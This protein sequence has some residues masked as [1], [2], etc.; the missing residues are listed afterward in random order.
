MPED[1]DA[2][3]LC[4]ERQ[5]G[6]CR[7]LAPIQT[8]QNAVREL[9]QQVNE[10][11]ML[12]YVSIQDV[13]PEPAAANKAQPKP[14]QRRATSSDPQGKHLFCLVKVLVVSNNIT[15][16]MFFPISTPHVRLRR[17]EDTWDVLPPALSFWEPLGLSPT[18]GPKNIMAYC[19]YPSSE[20]LNEPVTSFLDSIS[21]AYESC[22]FGSHVRGPEIEHIASNGLVSASV[23]CGESDNWRPTAQNCLQAVRDTCSSLGRYLSRIDFKKRAK[24]EDSP[25][26]DAIV[27]Y[28]VN[29]FSDPHNL[30]QLCSAFWALFQA[31]LPSNPSSRAGDDSRPELVLQLV[32]VKYIASFEA[33]VV[34]EPSLLTRFAREVYDRCPPKQPSN[35]HTALSI[36]SAPSIQ[37]EETLPKSIP[38]RVTAEPPS[39]LL[40]ENSYIHV[41][42]AISVDGAWLTAAWT[43]NPGKHQATVS[44]CLNNRSFVEVAREI[45]QTSL[46][47]MSARRVTWR[48]CIARA[49]VMERE[50]QDG[51]FIPASRSK[52]LATNCSSAWQVLVTSPCPLVI[53]TA[54]VSVNPNPSFCVTSNLPALSASQNQASGNAGVSTPGGNTPQPGVSPDAHGFTPAATPSDGNTSAPSVDPAS[55]PD[56]RLVDVTDES[57]GVILQHRL[58]NSNSTTEFR[59]ALASGYLIKRGA[60]SNT[61]AVAAGS[62][63][64]KPDHHPDTPRGPIAVGINLL[65]I[66]STPG[67]HQPQRAAQA[68]Q[69]QAAAA[70]AA[71]AQ[72]AHAHQ[73]ASS[74]APTPTSSHNPNISIPLQHLE[75]AAAAAGGGAGGASGNG[76]AGN[77]AAAGSNVNSPLP[78][79]AGGAM[80]QGIGAAA[81]AAAGHAGAGGG[82]PF[83]ANQARTTYDTVL[84]EFLIMYRGLGL[85]ARLKGMRGTR[86]GA[87]PWHVAAAMRGVRALERCV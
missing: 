21:M 24:A 87:V 49:G 85:L 55:D 43:D 54:L 66:G 72:A 81:A 11:D 26:V 84:R 57:W 61:D 25:K 79:P 76:N 78:S 62:N 50:E 71:A 31:Y 69:A 68:A 82:G 2:S 44:Y 45:Y 40:H 16:N 86:G 28:L 36:Y 5:T 35:D 29:P 77:A 1:E 32:P 20:Q 46:E 7:K 60:D 53:G 12:K 51:K 42:Y 39:D 64:G 58:H 56:A 63:A 37:L 48:L 38:F 3:L 9:F 6:A 52:F 73:S 30:W 27:V 83:A 8:I 75:A 15:V 17:G 80:G 67:G 70:A 4:L 23:H 33:P 59:P 41:G 13:I 74:A 10:C 47:I 65:W 34:L 19:V 22:K 18:S 14:V